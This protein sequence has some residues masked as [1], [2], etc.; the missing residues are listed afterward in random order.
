MAG[1]DR[2][3]IEKHPDSDTVD[4]SPGWHELS[5]GLRLRLDGGGG[6]GLEVG[7]GGTATS[8]R[9]ITGG[10]GRRK[11]AVVGGDGEGGAVEP[12]LWGGTR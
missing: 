9:E 7:D 10:V 3:R 6:L 5:L 12:L 11:R 2:L 4:P 8:G 1:T